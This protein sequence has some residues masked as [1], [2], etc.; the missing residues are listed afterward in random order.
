MNVTFHALASFATAAVLSSKL[1]SADS[2]RL[3]A[4]ADLPILAVG[5]VAGV[6]M[7]G[8]LDY[9]P[10]AYSIK[11]AVDVLLSLALFS[12]ALLL[13]GRRHWLLLGVCFL[14]CVFPD[15]VDLGPAIV[16]KRLGWSLPVVKVFPWHWRE[17]SGSIY[18][19]SR[20]VE[21]F[22][23]HLIVAGGSLILLYA[24]RR[25]LFR[26]AGRVGNAERI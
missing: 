11:S 17:Y 21:S 6:L 7:H 12:I 8:L 15:L 26:G 22:L 14:G 5:F 24:Y 4:P 16:N 13:A 25:Q 1:K 10:H 19:G 9:A 23:Y 20:G 2:R 3:F 18:D